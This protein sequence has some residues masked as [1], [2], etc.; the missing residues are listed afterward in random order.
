MCGIIAVVRRRSE[1]NVPGADAVVAKLVASAG[2]LAPSLENL[3]GRLESAA[4]LL[5]EVDVLLRGVAGLSALIDDPSLRADVRLRSEALG[6]AADAV[7]SMLDGPEVGASFQTGEIEAM[8]AALI[9]C[10]DSIW[11]ISRDRLRAAEQVSGLAPGARRSPRPRRRWACGS[12]QH[13]PG[14]LG[15]GPAR[16]QGARLGGPGAAGNRTRPGPGFAGRHCRDR[17][18]ERSVL[19]LRVRSVG[20]GD[21]LVIVHKAAAE[22]GELGDNTA[23]LRDALRADELLQAA[24]ASPDVDAVVLGHTRWA[25]IGIISEPNAHPAVLRRAGRSGRA[26]GDRSAQRRRRQLR[27]PHRSGVAAHRRGDHHRREGHPHPDV[28]PALAGGVDAGEAFRETV[29]ALE[30]S[31]AIAAA[32]VSAPDRL[33]LALRGSGQA[34]YV[35]LA[36]DAFIVAP[37]PYGVVEETATYLRMDGE[38]PS[39]PDNPT[40]HGARSSSSTPML[41]VP[42]KA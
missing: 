41:P 34:I 14:A 15:A 17:A 26:A 42:S 30:G 9:R 36:D 28:A 4:A 1:R 24:L 40:G 11:A 2:D 3:A 39:D 5:G 20:S 35:G 7:E 18:P 8:N 6:E 16:G 10:R 25:S 21:V 32:T 33:F 27:G 12:V 31:V 23:A 22:I 37:E 13:P 29:A 38:T 19:R